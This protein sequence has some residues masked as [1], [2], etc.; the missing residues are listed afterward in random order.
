LSA[1]REYHQAT[2]KKPE[3]GSWLSSKISSVALMRNPS[4]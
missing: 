2:K 4:C 3:N 1:L